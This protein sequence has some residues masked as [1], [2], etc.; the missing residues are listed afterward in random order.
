MTDTTTIADLFTHWDVPWA[1][2]SGLALTAMVY[3]RGWMGI[4]RTRRSQFPAWRLAAFLAGV[5]ALFI[6]VASPL[7]TFSE[8]LLFMHMTQHYVLM[9]V[10]PPLIVLGAPV[11]PLLRG[12][13]RWIIRTPLRPLFVSGALREAERSLTRPSVAWITMNAAYIGWHIPR[14]YEFALS[15]EGWH[16]VEHACFFFAN[17]MFWWPIIRPWPSGSSPSRNSRW[18]MVPYL[19]LADIVNTAVSA[20]LCFSGRLI[21][22]SYGQIARPLG[23]GA[24]DDQVAAGAFMW[25]FG[26]VVYLV[27][28]VLIVAQLLSPNTSSARE[29]LSQS[30][31]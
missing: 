4:H 25:V 24:L 31:A 18:L 8:S 16:N 5:V 7:D 1:V 15:S 19:M 11:V 27:P 29:S 22:P 20:F 28:A 14:A 2:T 23:I 3:A 13:P 6:A 21:Y 9:S 30:K 26:S 10:A 12:L 17:L